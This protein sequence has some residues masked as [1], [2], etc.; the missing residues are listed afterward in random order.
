MKPHEEKLESV[1]RMLAA[2]HWRGRLAP[3]RNTCLEDF[4]FEAMIKAAAEA[5]QGAWKPSATVAI[6]DGEAPTVPDRAAMESIRRVVSKI[7]ELM[8]TMGKYTH[9]AFC[10]DYLPN[11]KSDCQWS[12]AMSHLYNDIP[13]TVK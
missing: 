3:L 2:A 1:A 10:G 7:H 6:G 9:C 4:I 5:D 8:A 11:H 13:I 12:K